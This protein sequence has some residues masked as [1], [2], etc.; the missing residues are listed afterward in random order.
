MMHSFGVGVGPKE[1]GAPLDREKVLKALRLMLTCVMGDNVT[2]NAAVA[3]LLSVALGKCIPHA[4]SLTVKKS[5]LQLPGFKA[6]VVDSSTILWAGGT[7]KR[8]KALRGLGV[9]PNK[10]RVHPNRFAGTLEPAQYRLEKFDACKTFH[11]TSELLPL[12]K[13]SGF[14]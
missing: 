2:Y 14:D 13:S 11:T 7:N 5:L 6:L 4:L 8:V 3:R 9:D 1:P 10:L 12:K